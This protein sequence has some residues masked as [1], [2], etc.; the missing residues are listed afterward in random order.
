MH[1][2]FDLPALGLRAGVPREIAALL[3]S[4][5]PICGLT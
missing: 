3:D 1:R 5:E 4:G 2:P